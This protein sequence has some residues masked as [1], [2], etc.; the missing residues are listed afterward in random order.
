MDIKRAELKVTITKLIELAYS[1]DN[2]LTMKLMA[3]SGS[4]KLT[5]DQSGKATLSGAAGNLTFSGSPA[6]E[7]IGAKIKRV[8][9][10]FTRGNDNTVKYTATFSLEIISMSVSG[11]FDIEALILSCSGM[12]CRAGRAIKGRHQALDH[13]YQQIMGH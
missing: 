12:L 2:E 6:L 8:S 1:T 4:T 5:I 3:K 9:I 7:Q 11:E 10:S 13:E